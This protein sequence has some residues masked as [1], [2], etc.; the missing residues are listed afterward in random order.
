MHASEKGF[1]TE[2]ILNISRRVPKVLVKKI[3]T[4]A[5][6]AVS[7]KTHQL[8]RRMKGKWSGTAS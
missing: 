4:P 1:T 3:L 6:V 5:F 7:Y 8:A 2:K